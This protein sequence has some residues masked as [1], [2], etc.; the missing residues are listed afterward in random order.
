[1]MEMLVQSLCNGATAIGQVPLR[2]GLLTGTAHHHSAFFIS[3]L[4]SLPPQEFSPSR[5]LVK[6]KVNF[7]GEVLVSMKKQT[8]KH[9]DST[10]SWQLQ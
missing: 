5:S 3:G 10:T 4:F 7:V 8:H 1:M 2:L 9:N 6:D